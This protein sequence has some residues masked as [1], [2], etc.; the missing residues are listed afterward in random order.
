MTRTGDFGQ[1]ADF[2][3]IGHHASIHAFP[4]GGESIGVAFTSA[5]FEGV[6]FAGSVIEMPL[7]E[8]AVTGAARFRQRAHFFQLGFDAG[9]PAVF[10]TVKVV[11]VAETAAVRKGSAFARFGVVGV[12]WDGRV[13]RTRD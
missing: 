3:S 9:F 6:A 1:S 7:L 13:A 8:F 2:F 4:F 12:S 11:A 10:Q 5:V